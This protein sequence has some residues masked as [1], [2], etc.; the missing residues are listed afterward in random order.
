MSDILTPT[1]TDRISMKNR[2][3]GS[4][5]G[6]FFVEIP[7]DINFANALFILVFYTSWS[8]MRL[9]R[10]RKPAR[11]DSVAD[12]TNILF[13]ILAVQVGGLGVCGAV[14]IWIVQEALDAR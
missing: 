13:S 3:I 1:L 4:D 11:L 10:L 6:H 8:G 5:D 2:S 7:N 12:T 9:M 14:G